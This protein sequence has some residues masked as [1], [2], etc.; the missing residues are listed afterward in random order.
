MVT[1]IPGKSRARPESRYGR[2]VVEQTELEHPGRIEALD[3]EHRARRVD[4]GSGGHQAHELAADD[5]SASSVGLG[6]DALHDLV[7]LT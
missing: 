3:P 1:A 4:C 6:D 2:S 7:M 5:L